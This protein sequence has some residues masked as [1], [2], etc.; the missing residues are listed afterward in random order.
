MVF[1]Q[2]AEG[3]VL[4]GVAV[5]ADSA[6]RD[7]SRPGVPSGAVMPA[8]GPDRGD[9]GRRRRRR[10]GDRRHRAS[11]QGAPRRPPPAS[12]ARARPG[13]QVVHR[14]RAHARRA[15]PLA[16]RPRPNPSVVDAV[17]RGPQRAGSSRRARPARRVGSGH[18]ARA[19]PR[20][21]AALAVS[22]AGRRR[23][24]RCHAPPWRR[25]RAPAARRRTPGDRPRRPDERAV[26]PVRRL[27]A[28]PG[29]RRGRDRADALRAR[30]RR[31]PAPVLGPPSR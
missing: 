26:R 2:D 10:C 15:R 17:Q 19:A 31:R 20:G 5:L 6:P 1:D 12:D 27:G 13:E 16:V 30:R 29:G 3:E 25:A 11:A 7:R 8:R 18:G 28:R 23:G 9:R 14:R 21:R 4:E 22:A 24:G